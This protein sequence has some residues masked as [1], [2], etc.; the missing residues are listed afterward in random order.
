MKSYQHVVLACCLAASLPAA[1]GCSKSGSNT[2][3][4]GS[5]E[6]YVPT[7]YPKGTLQG[8]ATQKTI[9]AEGGSITSADGKIK[10][11][12]PA[13]AVATATSFSIQPVTN[14]APLG[15]GPSYRLLPENTAFSKPVTI[16]L[17]YDDASV[18][19]S[20]EDALDLAYQDNTGTWKALNKTT[21]D[22]TKHTLTVESTHFSDYSLTGYY[23][24]V[25][26]KTVV[27]AGD[28][29][30]IIV[31]RIAVP[32]GNDNDEETPL[33]GVE[34]V[35]EEGGLEGW[36]MSGTG[37]INPSGNTSV[38]YKA[39]TTV[40]GTALSE[41][42]VKV[43][44]IRRPLRMKGKV[45][46]LRRKVNIT[47]NQDF[48]AGTYDGQ[49]F[50]C[51]GVSVMTA[52]GITTIQGVTAQGKSVLIFINSA[53]VGSFPYGN[54]SN[55][56]KSEIRCNIT[57]DVYETVYTECGPPSVTKYADGGL[58]LKGF[59]SGVAGEFTATLYD[60]SNC[61]LKTKQISGSFSTRQ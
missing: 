18:E 52:G 25:P 21:L 37:E 11:T 7:T 15:A 33:G 46:T 47:P 61:G 27:F 24:L 12:I 19:G 2:P 42:L 50:N 39:P 5:N 20:N 23:V 17:S 54:P 59:Q 36:D 8:T 40:S 49:P 31:K 9:G 32:A 53:D 29:T 41:I 10:L 3:D 57:G 13:G 14:T 44:N 6:T 55:A 22:K 26:T 38:I 4:P 1:T 35:T 45:L 30:R 16:A 56:G 58:A 48:F 51:I 34:Q 60:D 28:T 43:K